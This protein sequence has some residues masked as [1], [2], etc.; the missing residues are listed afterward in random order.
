V[1]PFVTQDFALHKFGQHFPPNE[2]HSESSLHFGLQVVTCEYEGQSGDNAMDATKIAKTTK[3]CKYFILN[4]LRCD[5][6]ERKSS[7]DLRFVHSRFELS[8]K[9]IER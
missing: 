8:D 3:I 9:S 6:V 2:T 4:L 5:D 7:T 1:F